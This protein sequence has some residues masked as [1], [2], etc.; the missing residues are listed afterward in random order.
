[1]SDLSFRRG[2]AVESE[3]DMRAFEDDL[4]RSDPHH[5]FPR[6]SDIAGC[7]IHISECR[8]CTPRRPVQPADLMKPCIVCGAPRCPVCASLFWDLWRHD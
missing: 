1:M 4:H 8:R 6:G 2:A 5:L 7:G 3:T